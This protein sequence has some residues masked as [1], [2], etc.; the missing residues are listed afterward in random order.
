[1]TYV[2]TARCIDCRYMDCATVC[3]QD[4]F[5]EVKDPAMLVINPDECIDCDLCVPACPVN[6]IF[7][8]DDLPEPY[9]EWLEKNEELANS[10][11]AQ[12]IEDDGKTAFEPLDTAID[13]DEIKKR[14]EEAGIDCGD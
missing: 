13:L 8:D 2:V 3:P 14:E 11:E 5:Y 4:C 9:A 10:E 7:K 6:A 1:M 12:R